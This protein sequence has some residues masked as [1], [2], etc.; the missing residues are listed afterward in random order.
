MAFGD[1]FLRQPELFPRSMTG[2]P[3]GDAALDL[4]LPGGR[5]RFRGIDSRQQLWIRE[6]MPDFASE[7][8]E[9]PPEIDCFVFRAAP[10][11]FRRFDM[12]GWEYTLDV[13]HEPRSLL[14]AGVDLMA[15]IEWGPINAALWTST[16]CREA[17]WGAF[18]NLLRILCAH[19]VLDLQ[20]VILHS[21]GVVSEGNGFVFFGASGAGKTTISRLSLDGG[22]RVLSDDLNAV[23]LT[24]E[25]P[26]I[27]KLPF[28]GESALVAPGAASAPLRALYRLEKGA[29]NTLRRLGRAEALASLLAC[30]PGPNVNPHRQDDLLTRLQAIVDTTPVGV[31]TFSLD[32]DFWRLLEDATETAGRKAARA[33]SSLP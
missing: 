18:E 15:R 1:T 4:T 3:W 9:K 13:K 31:L 6:R 7:P 8:G 12:R 2:D 23:C 30:S 24:S 22:R 5:Y 28:C 14:L 21:A 33:G 17:F 32:G 20:G 10:D 19:R 11:V 25:G 26:R 27:E 29:R 16:T